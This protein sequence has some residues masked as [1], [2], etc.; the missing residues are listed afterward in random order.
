[1][2]DKIHQI[3]EQFMRQLLE[4]YAKAKGRLREFFFEDKIGDKKLASSNGQ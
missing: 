4:D 1:V 2:Q 3:E